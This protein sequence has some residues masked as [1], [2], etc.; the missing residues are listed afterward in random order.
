MR[1]WRPTPSMKSSRWASL[2]R[3]GTA[4]APTT[5]SWFERLRRATTG[6]SFPKSTGL[7]ITGPWAPGP[8]TARKPRTQLLQAGPGAGAVRRRVHRPSLRGAA[9]LRPR[10]RSPRRRRPRVGGGVGRLRLHR[11]NMRQ[12]RLQQ[13]PQAGRSAQHLATPPQAFLP[14]KP[15]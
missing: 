14:D 3:T 7:K 12:E 5:W 15:R 6:A 4:T 2:R 13:Q 9:R 1:A 11:R 10:T 8:S